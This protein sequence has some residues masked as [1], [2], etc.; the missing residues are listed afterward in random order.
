MNSKLMNVESFLLPENNLTISIS[1]Q[2]ELLEPVI[3][4]ELEMNFYKQYHM[5]LL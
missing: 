5:L 3:T 4:E 2:D 1:S